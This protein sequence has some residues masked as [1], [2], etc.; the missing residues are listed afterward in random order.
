[1]ILITWGYQMKRRQKQTNKQTKN[2]F[3]VSLAK[4]RPNKF[5]TK[6]VRKILQRISDL[7]T[8][9][10]W[11]QWAFLTGFLEGPQSSFG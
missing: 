1:M 8:N 7:G 11:V 10:R 9:T 3:Y 2:T 5:P 4:P 6:I